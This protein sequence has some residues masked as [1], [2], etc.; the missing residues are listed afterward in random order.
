MKELFS[1]VLLAGAF[2]TV[3]AAASAQEA[4]EGQWR[5]PKGS[6]VVRLSQCGNAYCGTVVRASEK[7]KEGAR[8]GGTT[9]LV[10][11][12]ILTNL[13]PAGKG[14]FKGQAFEPKRNI[15]AP[16]TIRMVGPD[17]IT[18]KGCAIAGMLLCKEQRW[19]RV[20]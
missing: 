10:G 5:N 3:P 6:L 12:R 7:A 17:A 1:K 13:R 9:N 19:T 11:T 18:V 14:T 2:L 8:K 15:R 16:A 4:L 20:S